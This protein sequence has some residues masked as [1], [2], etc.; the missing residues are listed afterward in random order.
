MASY[1]SKLNLILPEINDNIDPSVFAGNF[2]KIDTAYTN[3]ENAIALLN[4]RVDTKADKTS[5]PT[6]N[7][8]LINDA[9]FLVNAKGSSY[10]G[11]LQ[12][13]DGLHLIDFKWTG[14]SLIARIDGTTTLTL[15]SRYYNN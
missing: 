10:K 12:G 7:S 5:V 9:N 14:S 6:R 2:E 11:Y 3:T 13:Y 1:S 4:S 8:Q 15:A